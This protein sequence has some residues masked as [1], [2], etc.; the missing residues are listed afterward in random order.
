MVGPKPK[1][2]RPLNTVKSEFE[3]PSEIKTAGKKKSKK[4]EAKLPSKEPKVSKVS[5]KPSESK[6]KKKSKNAETA[7]TLSEETKVKVG[8]EEKLEP[9]YPEPNKVMLITNLKRK[10]FIELY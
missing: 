5:V 2:V 6:Q 8:V 10:L 7:P 1:P 9:A 3:K 4:A